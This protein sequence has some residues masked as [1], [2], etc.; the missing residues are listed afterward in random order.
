MANLTGA[1][2]GGANF[3]GT[4]LEGA[5][6]R[7]A[8]LSLARLN[9]A[10]LKDADFTDSN[11]WRA[12]GLTQAQIELLKKNFSPSEGASAALKADYEQW[13]RPR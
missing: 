8:D 13:M 1:K 12:R 9:E 3:T 5:I 4:R 2:L 10:N 6:L 7:T 11:W